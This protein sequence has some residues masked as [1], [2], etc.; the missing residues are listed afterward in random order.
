[1]FGQLSNEPSQQIEKRS[2]VEPD[3]AER[4]L[5]SFEGGKP[6]DNRQDGAAT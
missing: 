3:S 2:K 4:N 6:H 5:Q 1:M